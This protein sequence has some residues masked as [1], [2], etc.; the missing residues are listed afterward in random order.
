MCVVDVV[1]DGSKAR[2]KARIRS[3]QAACSAEIIVNGRISETIAIESA[4]S[5]IERDIPLD[6]TTWIALRVWEPRSD[7]RIRFAHSA[8]VWF[9][10]PQKP[11]RPR[12]EQAAFLIKRV[13]DEI[14]RSRDKLPPEAI[15]E[16]EAALAAWRSFASDP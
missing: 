9:D 13:E 8:P 7:E 10:D 14:E 5:L 2:F 12:P 1:R 3:S 15:A 16:Y 4:D 11:L 6:G